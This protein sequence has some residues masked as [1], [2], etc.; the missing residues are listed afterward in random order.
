M[1]WL[2]A[3][4]SALTGLALHVAHTHFPSQGTRPRRFIYDAQSAL[5]RAIIVQVLKGRGCAVSDGPGS[6]NS[7]L[8]VGLTDTHV[9]RK[10]SE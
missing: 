4:T 7:T 3:L 2:V 6:R 5:L 8:S 9:S 1:S 10:Q